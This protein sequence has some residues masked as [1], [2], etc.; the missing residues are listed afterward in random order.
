MYGGAD[1]AMIKAAVA[2]GA[3]GIVVQALEWGNMNIPMF[4]AVKEALAKGIPVVISTRA[5]TGR[6]L[7]V[8]GF[9]G[10]GK[11]LKDAGAIFADD[12]SPQKARLL[13]ALLI[14]NDIKD[15]AQVQKY[16]DK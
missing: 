2:N 4:N 1:G 16:F 15:S 11:T 14:Q 13:L 5:M 12:L 6:V 10:G 3:K 7:P 9:T 8:Y